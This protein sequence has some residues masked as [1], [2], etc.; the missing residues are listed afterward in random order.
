MWASII[1]GILQFAGPLIEKWIADWL[2]SKLN[3]K[4]ATL[5]TPV[6]FGA[7]SDPKPHQIALLKAVRADTWAFQFAKRDAIDALLAKVSTSN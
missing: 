2:Q 6:G 7:T 1:L 3:A 5:P 4:A